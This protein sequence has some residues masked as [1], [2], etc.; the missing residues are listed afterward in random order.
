MVEVSPGAAP[1]GPGGPR[2]GVHTNTAHPL[3]VDDNGPIGGPEAGNAMPA[4]ADCY[5]EAGGVSGFDR[6][7]HVGDPRHPDDR[8]RA[9]V[10][11]RVVDFP[12]LVVALLPW[13]DDFPPDLVLK[14][15]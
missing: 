7:H 5:R 11:H 3:E 4:T 2:L 12:S 15:L 14:I 9:L 10:D 13:E 1:F 8:G 6:G